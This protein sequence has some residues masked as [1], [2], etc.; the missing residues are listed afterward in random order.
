MLPPW[1]PA[2]F[3][4]SV[5]ACLC[6]A[7]SLLATP[8]SA[9]GG[10]PHLGDGA[11]LSL[12]QERALGD[13]IITSL[14]RDPD[15]LDDAPLHAY[16]MQIWQPLV[17]AALQRGDL[18]EELYQRFAWQ[19]LLGR[20]RSINAFALPG[21]YLGV[22][23]GLIGAVAHRDELATV[24][25]HELSHVTQRHIARMF[26]EEKKNIPLLI[27]GL[28]LG[29]LAASSSP[30]AAQ[31]LIIGGQA[32]AVQNQLSFSRDMEREADR[33]GFNL[34]SPA[35]FNPQGAASMFDKLQQAS[36]LND[37]GSWPYL[38]SHPLTSE[39]IADMQARVPHG[40]GAPLQTQWEDAMMSA[41]ARVLSQP[42]VDRLRQW[43]AQP[44]QSDFAQQPAAQR[45]AI[46][47]AAALASQQLRD[48]AGAHAFWRQ[49]DALV[50]TSDAAARRQSA[51]LGAELALAAGQPQQALDLVERHPAPQ[52]RPAVLLHAQAQLA[53]QR[54][55]LA[56]ERLQT[57]VTTHPQDAQAWQWL[58]QAWQAQN[59]PLR[60]LRAQAEAQVA[61]RDF[62]A[63]QDRLKAAQDLA[64]RGSNQ[65]H[66]EASI[67]D[68]RLRAVTE[69]LR[70]EARK[71]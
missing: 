61:I 52:L 22:H 65:D 17:Q 66:I 44:G 21:G 9:Q 55:A 6:M 11:E 35:G 69:L 50:P 34:L 3:V 53:L 42:G 46:L 27:G 30:D 71:Q 20:D 8:A 41:R 28:V 49:L 56:S 5:L 33:V 59:Q 31:A 12:S 29:A 39:R 51:W 64:R 58:A 48:T 43:V 15:Y 1:R 32:A 47:Y 45:A 13:S 14:Y 4:R 62:S 23:T 54:P 38:R 67:I 37:N 36:R 26:A 63:A 57:W 19:V 16:V 60:A 18:S 10:L 25:A 70:E 40:R 7:G 68:T 2:C 24:L